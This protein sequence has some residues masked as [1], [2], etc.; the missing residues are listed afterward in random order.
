[1]SDDPEPEPEPDSV[2][3]EDN[4]RQSIKVDAAAI[5]HSH[6]LEHKQDHSNNVA[7]IK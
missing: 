2:G 3:T 4:R 7:N 6:S 1:M 5:Q